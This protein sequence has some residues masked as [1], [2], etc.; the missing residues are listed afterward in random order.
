VS[1]G[2][3]IE[4]S[5]AA[6]VIKLPGIRAKIIRLG[7]YLS[8]PS[9]ANGGMAEVELSAKM[10]A[11]GKIFGGI[12]LFDGLGLSEQTTNPMKSLSKINNN[13]VVSIIK[14]FICSESVRRTVDMNQKFIARL[15]GEGTNYLVKLGTEPIILRAEISPEGDFEET[16]CGINNLIKSDQICVSYPNALRLSHIY[17]KIL[18]IEG[19]ALRSLALRKEGLVISPPINDRKVI[20]GSMWS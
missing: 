4:A 3:P 15:A 2:C 20:L 9:S 12:A 11:L 18:P 1:D 17:S 7:P 19:V 6:I 10:I 16:V 8:T 13:L 5:R 14:Q